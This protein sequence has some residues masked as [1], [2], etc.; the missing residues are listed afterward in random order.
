[1]LSLMSLVPEDGQAD[2]AI[3]SAASGDKRRC[4]RN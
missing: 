4:A 1:M 2:T 3:R